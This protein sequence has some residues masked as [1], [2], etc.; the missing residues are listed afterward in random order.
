MLVCVCVCVCVYVESSYDDEPKQF[1]KGE[2]ILSPS[3][4][5]CVTE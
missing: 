3:V 1:R 5:I 2:F 4:S